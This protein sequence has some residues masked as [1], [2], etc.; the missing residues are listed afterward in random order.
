M[1]TQR[2]LLLWGLI[3]LVMSAILFLPPFVGLADNSD[4]ARAVQ[5]LGLLPN[6]HP[7]YFH[8]FREFRL[9]E[10]AAGSLRNLL[11]PDLEN[12][13]GYVSSQLL[14]TKAALLLND[15][16]RRLLRMD[17][18]LFDIR[19]L[20]GLYI[21]L[22]GAGL[23]L[24]VA[25][26]GAKRTIARLLVFAAAIF[27]FCDAGYILY[28]HSFYGEATILV[29]LLLTAGSVAWCIYGNPS[30]KLPLFLFYAS[31]ALFVSAKV[32]NAPIGFLLALFGCAILFVR[33]DRFSRATVVAGSGAL[34]LFSMLFF[35]SAPQ[36]MKQVN[37][38][39]S[40]FFGVLKDSPTPAEDAA[41]LGL[42]P[43]YA[44]LRGTH[45]YM[46]D[47]PYDIYGDAFRRDVYDRVSYADILRFYVGH[48]DRLVEKLRVSA[49][50]SVFLRPSYVGNYEPDAGLERLSFTKRFSLWEGLRK[51][52]VGIAFPIVVA[53]F[54]CYLAAIAYRLVKLFRQPS[55]SPR[56]KLALS[57]VLL[58]LSTT[59][60]QWVVPVLGNGEADLQKHM[61]LFAA[62]FDLMLLVGAAW[63]ADR[64][65]AR[66]VLI[67]CAA[68]LLLPA[69]RWTQEP[70]SAP[71][72][73]ASGI[74][75]GDTVQ[76]GR[77]ED[78]PLLWTVLAKEEE[79]YLLW[80]RDAIAAKPFDAVDESLP[81]GEEARSYG[82]NDWETSDL[83]RWL[84]ETFLAGF[85]DE[86]RKL[87]TAAA[88]N[89]L[90]SA[91]RL[92]RKQFGDQPH[93][94]SSIPRHAEQNYDRAYGRRAS[95]L[96]F[97][98][99][100]QQLVRHVSM[101]GSFLTK[102]NP[103]GSATPYWVRTPYAGSA[104]MVRIVGEDGFVY[105]RDAA[106]ERTGVVP[107]VFLRL[108]AS[109][110]GGFGTP[111]RPYRVVGRA[112]VLPLARV[113]H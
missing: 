56:T 1:T 16:F 17:V 34:L 9:T 79:G 33:K 92:D 73:A 80:S 65:T 112:S 108:D 2:G 64:A 47:A 90:V 105:H 86:E 24:F 83:R 102:A 76:L 85:T 97:L 107:A 69:F 5:P 68:A 109:A 51:R 48:P 101:R 78:K 104:S 50:A 8:A 31:S 70:E 20:G 103:Q 29:A 111:E 88:L 82:S 38:Y 94:W 89:T 39:Q 100:A 63:I 32:A 95:E 110:Q 72:T 3:V 66:S 84:N 35:S 21:V 23:A 75:V 55:P 49:D 36:W 44:A 18:A 52:A 57:A 42:D 19:F 60:M 113:S 59:A 46:P 43:K 91:Q 58:L 15:G 27:L 62:C 93:Y 14:L 25:K 4:Y 11:F 12:E 53:G 98:L 87:L 45:G 96:V 106:G 41:E 74:R 71:A 30:R 61:F 7:R 99:D 26:L 10:A 40:I 6:E 37:Q 77:Y 13:L 54:A 67:V 28:F 81:A 22:Y